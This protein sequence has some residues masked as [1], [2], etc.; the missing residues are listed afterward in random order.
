MATV[1][2]TLRNGKVELRDPLPATWADGKE[3]IVSEPVATLVGLRDED[4]PTTPEG[5]AAHLALMDATPVGFLTPH[6]EEDWLRA[7]REYK[8]WELAHWQERS[9]R[10][11][12]MFE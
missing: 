8:E 2:G 7:L 3:V 9:G 1:T 10:I 5:I 11:R 6:E 4:W 12:G